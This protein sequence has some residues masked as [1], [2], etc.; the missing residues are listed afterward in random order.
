ML[1]RGHGRIVNVGSVSG[2]I[3]APMLG[4]YHA[5]KFALEAMTDALRM[6]V[7]PF[8]VEVSLIEPGTI[9]SGSRRARHQEPRPRAWRCSRYSSVY[10]RQAELAARFDRLASG[11]TPVTRALVHTIENASP[12]IGTHR[13]TASLRR[14][15]RSRQAVASLLDRLAHAP[16]RGAGP[17]RCRN[18]SL[19]STN[20]EADQ[21]I[22]MRP[23]RPMLIRISGAPS[24]QLRQPLS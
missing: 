12:A 24:S 14:D 8:G 10:A 2:R 6:E 3:P 22:G 18:L 13:R 9:R 19:I 11:P 23:C 21:N 15:D 16:H 7:A 20:E 5:S 17:A 1:A 4:A